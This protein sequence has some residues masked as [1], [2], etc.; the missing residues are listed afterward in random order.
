MATI[1]MA[2]ILQQLPSTEHGWVV[3]VET[4]GII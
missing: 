2:A 3:Y 1:A 4:H